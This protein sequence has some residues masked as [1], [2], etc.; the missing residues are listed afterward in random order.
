MSQQLEIIGLPRDAI[1]VT[2][3]T[4][5]RQH[6]DDA[7]LKELQTSI[8]RDGLTTPPTVW[9]AAGEGEE[10]NY[11]LIAGFC[12]M[13]AIEALVAEVDGMEEAYAELLCTEFVGDM[14]EAT[15]HNV[16]ENTIRK[17][18][19]PMD[20]AEA[21]QR[22][23]ELLGNQ[24]QVAEALCQSQPWVSNRLAL[25]RSLCETGKVALREDRITL[26]QAKVMT[27]LVVGKDKAP[28]VEKQEA[29]LSSILDGK[30]QREPGSKERTIHN[31]TDMQKLRSQLYEDQVVEAMDPQH[32]ASLL[33]LIQWFFKEVD[34]DAVLVQQEVADAPVVEEES[35]SKKRGR[36]P[37]S[38]EEA[39]AA[40]AAKVAEK[41]AA[42][43]AKTAEKEAAKAAKLTEKQQAADA[44][45]VLA[46]AKA[47]TAAAKTSAKQATTAALTTGKEP[48]KTGKTLPAAKTAA[49]V[50]KTFT[51]KKA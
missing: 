11:V 51:A 18:L 39:A 46:E 30:K 5:S 13:K 17:G 15:C 23:F 3:F 44:K 43:A 16:K 21:V 27:R 22:L 33:T 12:R 49:P 37:R 40:K 35:G 2:Y 1:D 28:D 19:P 29:Y 36:K 34:D 9:N 8:E 48:P 50:A 26:D 31:K 14:T 38:E 41:A 32:R 10:P 45:K 24:E 7:Y 47:A 25:V 42:L 4:N 20:G 6:Y